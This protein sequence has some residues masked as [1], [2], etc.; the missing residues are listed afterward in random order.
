M[1]LNV[2]AVDGFNWGIASE[3]DDNVVVEE[4]PPEQ[5]AALES[6][7]LPGA[8]AMLDGNDYLVN[9]DTERVLFGNRGD[10][11]I[12]GGAGN[13]TIFGGQGNDVIVGGPGNDVL[14]GDRGL[15]TLTGGGGANQFVMAPSGADRDVITDFQPGVDAIR[16]PDDFGFANLQVQDLDG[17][18]AVIRN[19]ETVAL[20]QGIVS[21]SIT[22]NEFVGDLGEIEYLQPAPPAQSLSFPVQGFGDTAEWEAS[23][24]AGPQAGEETSGRFTDWIS[25]EP[26]GSVTLSL[27]EIVREGDTPPFDQPNET[28]LRIRSV[29]DSYPSF[30]LVSE[31]FTLEGNQTEVTLDSGRITA[32]IRGLDQQLDPLTGQDPT[33]IEVTTEGDGSASQSLR[34]FTADFPIQGFGDTAQWEASLYAGPQAGEETSGRFTDWI[35]ADATGSVTLSVPEIVREGDTAPF[36]QPNETYLRVRSVDDSY[37]SFDLVSQPFTL[38]GD[39]AELMLE[40]LSLNGSVSLS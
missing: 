1:A 34:F 12:I 10:D 40:S 26:T 36:N 8:I 16:L 32:D 25:A 9:N 24:Y 39:Q 13:D 17:S 19:G 6:S 38:E 35:S 7:P 5:L 3:G 14:S 4:L 22:A 21:S 30:D 37:P 18:T 20:L 27:P 15:D 33:R 2:V 29:D 31:P 11:T 23:L 28:Y